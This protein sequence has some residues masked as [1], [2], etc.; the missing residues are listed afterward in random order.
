MD[1]VTLQNDID[2]AEDLDTH[3]QE[4]STA[5]EDITGSMEAITQAI[6]PDEEPIKPLTDHQQEMVDNF[7]AVSQNVKGDVYAVADQAALEGFMEVTASMARKAALAFGAKIPEHFKVTAKGL[8]HYLGVSQKLRERLVQL[9]PLVEKRDFPYTDVFD[10][11]AYSRFFQVGGKSFNS[12]S[13]F[14]AA[15]D[16]QSKATLHVLSASNSYGIVVMQKLLQNLQDLQSVKK[17]DPEQMVALRDSIER[18]WLQTW[19]EAEITTRPGETPQGALNAFPERKFISL[20]PLLDN[21]YLV[22]HQPK[23]NG[24][25]DPAK[26]TL[27]IRHY[28]ASVVFDKAKDKTTERSMNIPNMDDLSKLMIQTINVLHDMNGLSN[29][30]KQ[31][32]AFARDFKKTTDILNKQIADADDPQFYGFIAEYFK[33]A[34]AVGQAI[35]QPYIQMVWLYIRCAMVVV[36]MAELAVLED[37]GKRVVTARF[38][39]KQNTEFSN[40]A[41]ESFNLT[42]KVL[43]TA[44]RTATL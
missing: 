30:A 21:R 11:G 39:T 37:A 44:K 40:P 34:T 13:D 32:D 16:V 28:G 4:E 12:F 26:I 43:A 6:A 24:G 38:A 42:Q 3:L 20:A 14:Q 7:R 29:L 17:P 19:K 41:L 23:S 9:M 35:Q 33:I 1:K 8:L 25:S 2:V 5:I 36:S 27:A 31:N 15:M 10:Y 22:A 18:Y